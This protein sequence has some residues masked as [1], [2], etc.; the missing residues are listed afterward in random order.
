MQLEYVVN[1]QDCKTPGL[2]Q[3]IDKMA[4]LGQSFSQKEVAQPKDVNNL[5]R[6]LVQSS[7][8]VGAEGASRSFASVAKSGSQDKVTSTIE[9]EIYNERVLNNVL[10]TSRAKA[11]TSEKALIAKDLLGLSRHEMQSIAEPIGERTCLRFKLNVTINV[12]E[13]FT[14][15]D[16][17][18]I[19]RTN[20]NG[21]TS[22]L[23]CKI[24]GVRNEKPEE[25]QTPEI[26]SHLDFEGP[27][28]RKL[29]AHF[30]KVVSEPEEIVFGK[31]GPE[32]LFG[33]CSGNNKVD[34]WIS[35]RPPSMM[36]VEGNH[37]CYNCFG[38]GHTASACKKKKGSWEQNNVFLKDKV[39]MGP[40]FIGKTK[41]NNLSSKAV[42]KPVDQTQTVDE[43]QTV[44]ETQTSLGILSVDSLSEAQINR[45][46]LSLHQ[47]M[48]C[49]II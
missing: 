29:D 14:G 48:N 9:V 1:Y 38:C 2:S 42:E 16:L 46:C 28:I 15:K 45:P 21:P 5:S 24:L 18:Q 13:R 34:I 33:V 32:T 10:Q 43:I 8:A 17:L 7:P 35:Q 25:S 12:Q 37:P 47:Q 11:S 22:I 19:P 23:W 20:G 31:D 26:I 4:N 44:D 41:D 40:E 3:R 49:E 27:K 30:G 36:A 6:L 39:E